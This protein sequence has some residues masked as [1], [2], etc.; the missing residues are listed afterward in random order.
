MATNLGDRS[1]KELEQGLAEGEFGD[2]KALVAEEVLRRRREARADELKRKYKY[3]GGILA[4]LTLAF[5]KLRRL[6]RK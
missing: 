3:L 2:K 6:W 4:A 1:D 5:M